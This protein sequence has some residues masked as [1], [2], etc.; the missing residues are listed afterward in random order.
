LY[1]AEQ[2][3]LRTV[4]DIYVDFAKEIHGRGET[5]A[6][7]TYSFDSPTFLKLPSTSS[8]VKV[9]SWSV[10]VTLKI[11]HQERLW[12]CENV[13]MFI[14]KDLDDGKTFR[15]AQVREK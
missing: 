7:Q 9:T 13:V 2:R 6:R 8:V 4:R 11:E 14:L 15:I 3:F 10:E 1:D 5:Q 12:K